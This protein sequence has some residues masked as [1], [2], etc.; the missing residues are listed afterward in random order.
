MARWPEAPHRNQHQ[1]AKKSDQKTGMHRCEKHVVATIA[2]MR[3]PALLRTEISDLGGPVY[4]RHAAP[5]ESNDCFWVKVEA[6][7]PGGGF[8]DRH[9]FGQRI[10][11]ETAERVSDRAQRLKFGKNVRQTSAHNTD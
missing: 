6:P 10:D 9:Q 1:A 2:E 4:R 7:H 3:D 8:H 11:P 5:T